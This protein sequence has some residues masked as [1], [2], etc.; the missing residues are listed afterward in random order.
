MYNYTFCQNS[1]TFPPTIHRPQR[2]ILYDRVHGPI[3]PQ[4]QPRHWPV[5]QLHL[6]RQKVTESKRLVRRNILGMHAMS[7]QNN[8]QLT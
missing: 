5:L 3:A 4:S 6:H 2:A 8:H 1:Y 7:R